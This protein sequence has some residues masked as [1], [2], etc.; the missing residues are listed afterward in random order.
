MTMYISSSLGLLS[1]L[2]QLIP[3]SLLLLYVYTQPIFIQLLVVPSSR[4]TFVNFVWEVI[5]R[6]QFSTIFTLFVSAAANIMT[7]FPFAYVVYYIYVYGADYS[8]E[9]ISGA[10]GTF[11]IYLF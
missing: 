8:S 10:F 4:M 3:A 9:F 2:V 5:I 11:V 1:P 7:W 6:W